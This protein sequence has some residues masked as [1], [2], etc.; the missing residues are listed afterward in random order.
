PD[1]PGSVAPG[2]QLLQQGELSIGVH[3][4]P[5]AVMGPDHQ[6]AFSRELPQRLPL[7]YQIVTIVEVAFSEIPFEHQEATIDEPLAHLRLFV[8]RR[9]LPPIYPQHSEP[10]RRPDRRHGPDLAV[11]SMKTEQRVDVDVADTIAIGDAEWTPIQILT[12][13]ADPRASERRLTGLRQRHP[14]A[15]FRMAVV[16]L[17]RCLSPKL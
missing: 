7:Q 8:K 13:A 9:H 12:D 11:G 3:R 1:L 6:L 17:R 14:P 2:P 5:E 4:L 16:K 10:V 15:F